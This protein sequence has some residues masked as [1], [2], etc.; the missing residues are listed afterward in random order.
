MLTRQR[1]V[2]IHNGAVILKVGTNGWQENRDSLRLFSKEQFNGGLFVF[3][4][5]HIPT[6][7]SSE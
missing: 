3:D 5:A 6:G 7:E 2:S 4:I 1:R